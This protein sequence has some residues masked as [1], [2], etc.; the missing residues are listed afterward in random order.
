MNV[1]GYLLTGMRK[2]RSR[3]HSPLILARGLT[4][5]FFEIEARDEAK[6]ARF[7]AKSKK[8]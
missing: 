8:S 4:T 2:Y 6:R 1:A 7:S 3:A 5:E